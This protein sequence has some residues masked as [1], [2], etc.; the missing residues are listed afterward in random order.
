MHYISKNKIISIILILTSLITIVVIGLYNHRLKNQL[1]EMNYSFR[2]LKSTRE[3]DQNHKIKIL[4]NGVFSGILDDG[5]ILNNL[6]LKK[7]KG[8]STS[9]KNV[10]ETN[11]NVML[12]IRISEFDCTTCVDFL[13]SKINRYFGKK[14]LNENII[15]I[16]SYPDNRSLSAILRGL[17][18]E[19]K[20]YNTVQEDAKLN[21][22]SDLV[23]Y[24]YCFILDKSMQVRHLFIP[25]K[26][27]PEIANKYFELVSE[28]YF[29]Q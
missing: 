5:N 16:G 27:Y 24:P 20:A 21:I 22:S 6:K 17:T 1:M 26:S 25:N 13:L 11:N 15:I 23:S 19:F 12:V 4:E 9:L 10:L 28:K 14:G 3:F 29:N 18:C 2:T 7:I 8:S